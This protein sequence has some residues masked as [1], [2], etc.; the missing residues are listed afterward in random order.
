MIQLSQDMIDYHAVTES[1]R[2]HR[3]GAVVL[4]LGTVREFTGDAHTSGLD[5]EAYRA[6]AE[7]KLAEL[8]DTVL[9]RYP[10]I[11]ASLVHRIGSLTLGDVCVAIAVSTPHRPEA[12]E[13]GRWLI[14]TLKEQVPI[15]KKE[16]Y[17]DGSVE[18]VHPA[19]DAATGEVQ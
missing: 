6:M 17:M 19:P 15:W 3:A 13:A 2:D 1:V 18:W 4:F 9:K 11:K 12:F 16:N 14:D 8:H 10:V 7:T 5:Y